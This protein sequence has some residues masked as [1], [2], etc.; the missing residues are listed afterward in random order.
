MNVLNAF[1]K[2]EVLYFEEP[3]LKT[4][5]KIISFKKNSKV[6]NNI[7]KVS[8]KKLIEEIGFA[9]LLLN[10]KIHLDKS[11]SLYPS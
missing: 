1:I 8:V 3:S 4:S 6:F 7:S 11:K 2:E 9:E 5:K 10:Q